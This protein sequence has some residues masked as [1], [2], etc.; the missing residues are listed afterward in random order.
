M[1]HLKHN[2]KIYCET[3]FYLTGFISVKKNGPLQQDFF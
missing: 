3:T 2:I 1:L